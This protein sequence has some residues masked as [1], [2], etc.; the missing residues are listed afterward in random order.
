MS[1][2]E[3]QTITAQE[4]ASIQTRLSESCEGVVNAVAGL[5][6]TQWRFKP[7]PDRWS[8]VD[9][10]E[11]LAVIEGRV[12]IVLARMETAPTAPPDHDL[13][14]VDARVLRATVDRRQPIPAPEPIL[15][16]GRWTPEAALEQYREARKKTAEIAA[17]TPYLR[18]RVI[19]HPVLGLL[20]GCQW[21][22]AASAHSVRHTAQILEVKAA[23]NFPAE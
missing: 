22:L 2:I 20:D 17:S 12:H 19:P 7:A 4:Q 1:A 14:G 5:S 9:V 13:R 6:E 21:L 16:T 23:Q 8:V 15:P 18:G 10:V 11:H 3:P